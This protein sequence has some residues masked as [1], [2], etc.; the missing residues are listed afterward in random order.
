[1]HIDLKT[2]DHV[3]GCHSHRFDVTARVDVDAGCVDGDGPL[4][5]DER[6]LL[7]EKKRQSSQM[8]PLLYPHVHARVVD[9]DG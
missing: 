8:N 3:H 2:G 5:M 7:N 1:M 9:D 4:D 6:G